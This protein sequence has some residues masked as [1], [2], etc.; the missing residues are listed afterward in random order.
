MILALDPGPVDTAYV[1]VGDDWRVREA[2]R[3]RRR[4]QSLERF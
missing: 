3:L 2:D 4:R 1:R